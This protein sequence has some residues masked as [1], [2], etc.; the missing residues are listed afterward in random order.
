MAE[1]EFIKNIETDTEVL[2]KR[3]KCINYGKLTD[4]YRLYSQQVPRL[5]N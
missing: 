4:E 5:L 1:S 2:K 3:Q